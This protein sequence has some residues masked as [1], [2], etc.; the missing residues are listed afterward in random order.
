MDLS[1]FRDDGYMVIPNEDDIPVLKHLASLHP[2]I[3]LS[4]SVGNKAEYVFIN[5]KL[6]KDCSIQTDVLRK[7]CKSYLPPTSC[8]NPSVFKGLAVGM[9]T[10]LTI[11]CSDDNILDARLNEYAKH[12]ALS[13]WNFDKDLTDLRKGAMKNKKEILHGKRK[14]RTNKLAR[15]TTYDPRLPSK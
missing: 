14:K 7:N 12:L 10:R 6:L 1:R 5:L 4:L 2:D 13:G 11:L 8:H 3:K 15:V 9:G